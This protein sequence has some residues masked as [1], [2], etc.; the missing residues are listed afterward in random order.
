MTPAQEQ[1]MANTVK[2]RLSEIIAIYQ[3]A[4]PDIKILL[5][6]YDFPRFTGDNQIQQYREVYLNMGSPTP[7]EINS[8]LIR[9][10]QILA[11]VADQKSVFY[12]QHLGVMHYYY[13]NPSEGLSPMT[14]MPPNLISSADEPTRTGGSPMHLTDASAMLT[15][16]TAVDAFHLNRAGFRKLS[17]HAVDNYIKAWMR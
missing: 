6:G 7:L 2:A 5:S 15:V 3:K 9:F 4:R 12:I 16:G 13:G 17:D 8:E 11:T 10:S 14:T 1:D